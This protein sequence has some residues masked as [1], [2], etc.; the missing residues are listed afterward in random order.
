MQFYSKTRSEDA[1]RVDD[2]RTA[3]DSETPKMNELKTSKIR[4]LLKELKLIF[5]R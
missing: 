4:W 2:E 5:E 3:N 1:G